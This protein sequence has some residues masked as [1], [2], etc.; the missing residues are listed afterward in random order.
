LTN[1]DDLSNQ[2]QVTGSRRPG[3]RENSLQI[4]RAL[5]ALNQNRPS[6]DLIC[7]R[8]RKAIGP[9][10]PFTEQFIKATIGLPQAADRL[11]IVKGRNDHA[12][13]DE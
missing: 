11:R 9:A 5:R 1:T 8:R 6:A 12:R 7:E 10:P 3:A 13:R 4:Q 2:A